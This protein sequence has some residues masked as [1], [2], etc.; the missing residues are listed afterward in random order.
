MAWIEAHEELRD[1]PKTKR[2]ARELRLPPYAAIGLLFNLW[3]WA[4]TYA[5]DG[6]I[7]ELEDWEIAEATGYDGK[8]AS[9]LR[10]SL[11]FSG[12]LDNTEQGTILIHGWNEH[13]GRILE[14]RKTKGERNSSAYRAFREEVLKRD[15]YTCQR[16]GKQH[17]KLVVHHKKRFSKYP[18]LRVTVS[19]GVTLCE[20]C[21]KEVH[22]H[23]K[24]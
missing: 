7:T 23:E 18:E 8:D 14:K 3:W 20:D 24:R 6:D 4:M 13:E 12:F 15:N 5:K 17:G 19:N 16:C 21:H 2:L 10:K 1:H 9:K 22:A 11:I